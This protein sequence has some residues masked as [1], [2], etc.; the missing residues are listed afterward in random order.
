MNRQLQ[1]GLTAAL[2]PVWN[3]SSN[4]KGHPELVAASR[5]PTAIVR[6]H[7]PSGGVFGVI[8]RDSSRLASAR[9]AGIVPRRSFR[10][11]SLDAA[12]DDTCGEWWTGERLTSIRPRSFT[13]ATQAPAHGLRPQCGSS[14]PVCGRCWPSG[15]SP[16]RWRCRAPP[17]P[18]RSSCPPRA[19][20]VLPVHAD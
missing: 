19:G 8:N 11:R 12:R 16:C 14:P 3:R 17:L 18:R 10:P 20:Q 13:S 4:L 1:A 15:S 6:G 2:Q 9:R 7:A 5:S